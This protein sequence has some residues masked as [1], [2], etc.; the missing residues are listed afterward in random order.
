MDHFGELYLFIR[1][2][3]VEISTIITYFIEEFI[4][5]KFVGIN[6]L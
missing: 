4:M 5:R 3:I 1:L 2:E 6:F